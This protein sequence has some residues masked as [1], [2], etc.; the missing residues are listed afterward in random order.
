MGVPFPTGASTPN[1][2]IVSQN[3][4]LASGS[5]RRRQ[6]LDQLGLKFT[7]NAPDVDE[8]LLFD[9]SP[10][11]YVTRLSADKART[12]YE[13]RGAGDCVVIAAD[14]T[15][16]ADGT[17]LGK[18]MS[19]DEGIAM[20][21]ALSGRQHRVLT[22]VTILS[23]RVE[24]FCVISL[25]QFRELLPAEMSYY[26][27]TG[28]PKDKAGGYGLQGLGAAFV[29]SIHGSYTNVIGLPISETV[30]SL[31]KAG[32]PCLGAVDH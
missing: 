3:L 20:L 32:V 6:L 30:L 23:A 26:W 22:G 4:I 21:T 13:R 29:H 2:N 17:V 1:G 24:T 12:V 10:E 19:K 9:E 14:T 31:R 16:D 27:D 25:V 7:I 8:S 18:P 28:E 5:P 15:V 11:A